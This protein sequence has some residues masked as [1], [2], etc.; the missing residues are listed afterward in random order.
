MTYQQ[1]LTNYEYAVNFSK[2]D[3]YPTMLNATLFIDSR[4]SDITR[5]RKYDFI[6]YSALLSVICDDISTWTK[7]IVF[8]VEGDSISPKLEVPPLGG[9]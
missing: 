8:L 7:E 4:F 6:S 1:L 2:F 3:K 5:R 9:H